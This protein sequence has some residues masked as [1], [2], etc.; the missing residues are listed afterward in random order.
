VQGWDCTVH[1][2]MVE[3]ACLQTK[4][5]GIGRE[6]DEKGGVSRM[7]VCH[8]VLGPLCEPSR[9]VLDAK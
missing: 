2:P 1:E 9:W 8:G 6:T 7:G 4:Q 5:V 3:W